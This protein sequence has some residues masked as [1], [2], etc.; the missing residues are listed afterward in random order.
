MFLSKISTA[1]MINS[2]SISIKSSQI[3]EEDKEKYSENYGHV[4][5][6]DGRWVDLNNE[7]K[8][9][10]ALEFLMRCCMPRNI[11]I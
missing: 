7:L 9:L 1:V 11:R 5:F 10:L 3:S 2:Q 6:T 4:K 8:K